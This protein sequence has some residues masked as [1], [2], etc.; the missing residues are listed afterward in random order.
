MGAFTVKNLL[1]SLVAHLSSSETLQRHDGGVGSVTQQQLAGL[2]VTSQ[3]SSVKSCLAQC[4]H[5]VYLE[6]EE[7]KLSFSDTNFFIL[8][9]T[10]S[11]TILH[12]AQQTGNVQNN[13]P[14]LHVSAGPPGYHCELSQQQHAR[15][16]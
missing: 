8:Q 7:V 13:R 6:S 1:H 2:D 3:R 11:D 10:F 5:S 4:V 14:L 16:S 12:L 15:G 9:I